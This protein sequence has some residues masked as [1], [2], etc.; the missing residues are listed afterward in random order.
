[1]KCFNIFMG[2]LSLLVLIMIIF[3]EM[4][5]ADRI[6][7]DV[8]IEKMKAIDGAI[9]SAIWGYKQGYQD[10]TSNRCSIV[11]GAWRIVNQQMATKG[12][13]YKE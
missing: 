8:Q 13:A 6:E 9:A 5:V 7:R 2:I 1:M 12:M 4:S 10:C 11:D 3:M